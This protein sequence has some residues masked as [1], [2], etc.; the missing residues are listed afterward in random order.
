MGSFKGRHTSG[1]SKKIS[2]QQN[3]KALLTGKKGEPT[4]YFGKVLPQKKG[5]LAAHRARKKRPDLFEHEEVG[6]E[7]DSSQP[8]DSSEDG[9]P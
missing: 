6:E 1:F 4:Q 8:E 7:S 5:R 9:S 3:E 2:H